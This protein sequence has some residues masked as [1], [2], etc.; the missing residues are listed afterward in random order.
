M[1]FRRK[2]RPPE[3]VQSAL[4]ELTRVHQWWRTS[5]SWQGRELGVVL[6]RPTSQV[7]LETLVAVVMAALPDLVALREQALDY[8]HGLE[9][10]IARE[11][12]MLDAVGAAGARHG[13][14][15]GGPFLILHFT[16]A[17]DRNVIDVWF[18][19]RQP[20]DADYH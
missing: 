10:R 12:H 15:K 20:V 19:G 13:D 8:L 18:S 4:G 11:T 9:P 17:D 16:L 5:I 6:Q 3:R 1:W 2:P 7:P 14:G